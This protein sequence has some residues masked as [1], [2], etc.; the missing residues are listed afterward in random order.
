MDRKSKIS[1]YLLL[2]G[3][4]LFLVLSV[5]MVWNAYQSAE[6]QF[7]FT[8]QYYLSTAFFQSGM[9]GQ[10]L[11]PLA[12]SINQ[13]LGA[14]E[15]IVGSNRQVIDSLTIQATKEYQ[16]VE[17]NF[18]RLLQ[19]DGIQTNFNMSVIVSKFF[20]RQA[21]TVITLYDI[22]ENGSFLTLSGDMKNLGFLKPDN[23]FFYKLNRFNI[24]LQV[25]VYV[26]F[27]NI[28]FFLLKQIWLQLLISL[29]ML[30]LFAGIVAYTIK[31]I[32]KQQLVDQMKT[33]FINNMTHELKTPLTTLSVAAKTIDPENLN[34]TSSLI[35]SQV[36]RLESVVNQV[37]ELSTLYEKGIARERI[38][39]QEFCMSLLETFA[40]QSGEVE[41]SFY[42]VEDV[43]HVWADRFLLETAVLNLLDNAR[44]YGGQSQIF[45]HV[46]KSGSWL[47]LTVADEGPG[48]PDRF[49]KYVFDKFYRVPEG[50][51]HEVKGS[52]LGLF[53]V[54]EIVKAHGGKVKLISESGRG[55]KVT[56]LIPF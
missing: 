4:I 46:A 10:E 32:R 42:K 41:L 21:D 18:G 36:K 49:Q 9:D 16:N 13:M 3:A 55:T 2:T 52:G 22:D 44:K 31:T 45:M 40:R 24:N 35:T 29:I 15:P 54:R 43:D 50:N 51:R 19:K 1:L 37:M 7:K 8:K 27:P 33:D 14:A 25:S 53:H 38:P 12:D 5:F 23:S 11:G 47:S 6:R 48:I 28:T 56:V 34:A 26:N 17:E 30:F 20:I 39:V